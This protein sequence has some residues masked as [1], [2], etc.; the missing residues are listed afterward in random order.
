[1]R[2]RYSYNSDY[3][4]LQEKVTRLE[5]DLYS[6]QVTIIQLMPEEIQRVLEGYYSCKSSGDT[7]I[8]EATAANEIIGFAK[9]L[10]PQ[11]GSYFS[12]RAYCPLCGDSAQSY[13]D[14]KGF[15]VP[16][17]LYRHLSGRGKAHQCAVFNA[18]ISLARAYWHRTFSESDEAKRLQQIETVTQR[19]ATE[20]LFR[21]SPFDD[22]ILIDEGFW[23]TDTHR[24]NQGIKW[25][26]DRLLSLGF[27]L[28]SEDRIKCYVNE[29]NDSIVFADPRKIGEIRFAVFKKPLPKKVTQ[30]NRFRTD[31]EFMIKDNWKNDLCSKFE[32]R[33]QHVISTLK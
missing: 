18:V 6:A 9:V 12:D 3:N 15:T 31:R 30:S 29:T 23:S 19:R 8:W 14:E 7:H 13:S 25:A 17:G 24:D 32:V 20:T 22:P 10:S 21:I 2:A 28:K 4:P 26:E 5:E 33:V 16:L 27:V 1:M 11:E